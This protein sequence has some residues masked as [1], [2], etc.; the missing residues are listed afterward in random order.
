MVEGSDREML[1]STFDRAAA[2]YQ[3]ARP[4]YPAALYERLLEF[5]SV[6]PASTLLEIGCATG[7]ATLPLARRGYPITCLEPGPAL[8]AEARRNLA[9]FNVEIV[10][11]RFEDW[12]PR[13]ESFSLVYAAT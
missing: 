10:E 11:A 3:R 5:T 4:E 7:K 6:P 9:P 13:P 12:T 1:A 2:L 8:A